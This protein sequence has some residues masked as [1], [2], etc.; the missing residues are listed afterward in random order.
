MLPHGITGSPE[1]SSQNAARKFQ[2]FRRPMLSN[3]VAVQQTVCEISVVE[4]FC[5]PE[6]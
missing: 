2:L 6:K 1:Q 3:F 4:K 5:S